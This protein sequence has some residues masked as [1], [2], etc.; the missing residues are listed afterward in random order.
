MFRL[1][2]A[3]DFR[4]AQISAPDPHHRGIEIIRRAYYLVPGADETQ[5][6]LSPGFGEAIAS[7]QHDHPQPM[8]R[9]NDR[10]WWIFRDR[11][12]STPDRLTRAAVMRLAERERIASLSSVRA[13]RLPLGSAQHA[14][15]RSS[16]L[17]SQ[18]SA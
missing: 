6:E 2:P 5:R 11:I 4:C 17:V 18:R 15:G 10:Y 13:A 3:A 16:M 7:A 1:E 14:F 9:A 12:Y 8:G